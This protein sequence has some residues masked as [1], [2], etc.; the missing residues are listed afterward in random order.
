MKRNLL[1][2]FVAGLIICSVCACG[3]KEES[4][5]EVETPVVEK[6][7][8]VEKVEEPETMGEST[9]EVEEDPEKDYSYAPLYL[10]EIEKLHSSGQA[11]QFALIIVDG[12]DIPEL[13]AIHSDYNEGYS[14]EENGGL[15]TLFENKIVKLEN[16]WY[17]TIG[18]SEGKNLIRCRSMGGNGNSEKFEKINNGEVENL[19][20][21][22]MLSGVETDGTTGEAY[23]K[24]TYLI[25][26]QEVSEQKYNEEIN[27]IV[28]EYYPIKILCSDG[29]YI[30][31]KE[32]E[33]IEFNSSYMTYEE[34]TNELR[35]LLPEETKVSEP[36]KT[37]YN[38]CLNDIIN[39]NEYLEYA[40]DAFTYNDAGGALFALNDIT[41][42][43]IP[44]LLVAPKIS[45][46]RL[47]W[48]IY[49]STGE[50]YENMGSMSFYDSENKN[51][52]L[53]T[54][55]TFE[56]YE[57]YSINDGKLVLEKSIGSD[58][59]GEFYDF[60]NYPDT[61]AISESDIN[62]FRSGFNAGLE[63]YGIKGMELT[64]ENIDKELGTNVETGNKSKENK[65]DVDS[66]SLLDSFLHGEIPAYRHND[67]SEES[68]FKI[69]DLPIDEDDF[70]SYHIGERIDLDND[71]EKELILDG[72]DGGMYLDAQNGKIIVL[73]ESD[74][75]ASRLSHVTYDGA[76][77][78][79]YSDTSHAGRQ[80]YELKKY[81]GAGDVVDS[82]ELSA[83]YWDSPND[84]YNTN[85]D[86]HYRGK[87]ISMQE[88]EDLIK[89]IFGK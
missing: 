45:G 37:A 25:D 57:I 39:G 40:G 9:E 18:Y 5:A 89:K 77:W 48:K 70:Y 7:T 63:K 17:Q 50:G 12:D 83:E 59:M 30:S 36:W 79:V 62:A 76:I 56:S 80:W 42:D 73:A 72:A 14:N 38:D 46:D 52:Y 67:Y 54:S 34:I 24:N 61:P 20:C 10:D 68:S 21:V 86:F 82:F 8:E 60:T 41:G 85:S 55:M 27:K 74:G 58:E 19:F 88:Y 84:Q 66:D 1:A 28:D 65:S 69:T 15:Y 71:G 53:D 6:A 31:N 64:K 44:E 3:K 26:E 78:I 35:K 32:N 75:T 4:V 43:D 47:V 51:V 11:D 2:S 29:I 33:D 16:N 87:K 13:V 22:D 81:N 49:S 23:S